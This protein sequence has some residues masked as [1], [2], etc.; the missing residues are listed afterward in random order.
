MFIVADCNYISSSSTQC[1]CPQ[2]V[3]DHHCVSYAVRCPPTTYE[4]DGVII[5]PIEEATV[6][7]QLVSGSSCDTDSKNCVCEGDT[8]RFGGARCLPDM[9]GMLMTH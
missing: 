1:D 4:P 6:C 8:V 2:K 7:S 3:T 9:Q 5:I